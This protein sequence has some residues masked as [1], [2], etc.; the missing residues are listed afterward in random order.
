MRGSQ[1]FLQLLIEAAADFSAWLYRLRLK[2]IQAA[3]GPNMVFASQSG[4]LCNMHG[5][6]GSK[7]RT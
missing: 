6:A 4:E 2:A 1:A 7:A 5:R 3:S